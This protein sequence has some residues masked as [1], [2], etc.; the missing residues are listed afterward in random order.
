MAF[1]KEPL[2]GWQSNYEGRFKSSWTHH[3]TSFTFSI[4]GW[5]VVRS[6]LLANGGA[7][8]KR[9]SLHLHKVLTQSNEVSPPTSQT[10]LVA[11]PSL[12]GFF[13]NDRDSHSNDS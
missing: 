12:K 2:L 10:V 4:S 7:S 6:A 1:L 11:L 13:Q 3:I 5:S 8:R 9:L